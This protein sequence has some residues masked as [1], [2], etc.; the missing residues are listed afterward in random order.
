MTLIKI[1]LVIPV[2][3]EETSIEELIESIDQQVLLPEEVVFVDGGSTDQ[4]VGLIKR[5]ISKDPKYKII[6]S[7]RSSP[8]KGRNLGI[9]NAENEWIALTDAGIKLEKNWLKNLV[10]EVENN[11]ETDLVY[12]SY[13]PVTDSFFDKCAALSYVPA[14]RKDSIRGKSVASMLLKKKVWNEVGGFPDLRAAED[15]IFIEAVS[16]KNFKTGFAPEAMMFWQ[17]K[18]TLFST[19]IKFVLYSKHNV[20][21]GRAWDWHYGVA[22][23]YLVALLFIILA[24]IN[25]WWWLIMI[26]LWIVARVSKRILSHRFEYGLKPLLNPIYFLGITFIILVIDMATF[27]GWGQALLYKENREIASYLT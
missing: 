5:V 17:L 10:R 20:W 12:G 27:I 24:F 26:F 1:S 4:T 19:F 23:Q 22:K 21:A 15:L 11:P 25:S 2:Y 6:R 9:K 13:A 16:K 18:P 7:F 14:L 8:G 3:N